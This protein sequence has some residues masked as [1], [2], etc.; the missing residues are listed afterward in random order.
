MI[1]YIKSFLELLYP[2]KNICQICGIRD[3]EIN[4]AYICKS[5][6]LGL[7][8]IQMPVCGI[9]GKG[10]SHNPDSDVCE[11]CIR[12]ERVFEAAKSPFYYKGAVKKLIHD[13]KYCNKAY[14]YKLFGYLLATHMK[15]NNYTNFDFII[16]VPL[17]K[18][19]LRKR[20]YNQSELLAKYIENQFNICCIDALKRVSDTQKQSS[21][22][23]HARQKNLQNAFVIKNNKIIKLIEG[24]TVLIVDDIFTTGATVNEC[25]RVLKLN[26]AGKVYALTIAR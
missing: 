20:G 13:Y 19:K 15:E 26:G 3:E 16:S 2:E 25:S 7:K 14:Y 17:H 4:D 1:K 10:L 21:L 8:R 5:C 22:S 11:E 24:K 12:Q 18:I 9:C 6:L 23:R